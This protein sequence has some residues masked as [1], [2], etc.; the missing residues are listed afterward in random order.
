MEIKMDDKIIR[1]SLELSEQ[2][3]QKLEEL[4][5]KIHKSKSDVLLYSIALM[6]VAIQAKENGKKFGIANKNQKLITEIVGI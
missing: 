2:L 3:N 1:L 6:E 4:A 5:N